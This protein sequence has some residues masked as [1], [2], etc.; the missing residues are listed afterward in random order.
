MNSIVDETTH[1]VDTQAISSVQRQRN[2][3]AVVSFFARI[4]RRINNSIRVKRI[5]DTFLYWLRFFIDGQ[6]FHL[7]VDSENIDWDTV[8]SL[9]TEVSLQY[10]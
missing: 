4:D 5:G 6:Q 2:L 10:V 3:G 9:A 8:K 7:V 1:P